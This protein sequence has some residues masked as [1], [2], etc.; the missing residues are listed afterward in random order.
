MSSGRKQRREV[1]LGRR[2][3]LSTASALSLGA[4]AALAMP[5]ATAAGMATLCVFLHAQTNAQTLEKA[6]ESMLPGVTV[7][8]LSRVKDFETRMRQ[9]PDAVLSLPAVLHA[10]ACPVHLQGFRG[11]SSTEAY[12]LLSVKPMAPA[13]VR[14][15]GAVD[16]LGRAHM[17]AFVGNLLGGNTPAVTLVT[18]IVD[19]LPLLQ[20]DKVDAVILPLRSVAWLKA[21]TRVAMSVTDL[22]GGH[23][24][25]PAVSFLSP[26]G[27]RLRELIVK[28][29]P[30]LRAEIGVETWR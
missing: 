22:P 19:L 25:L 15:I 24:G 16:L 18:K 3:F 7:S 28:A 23:V 13:R 27:H 2:A 1:T 20:F 5:P 10:Q 14:T 29:T 26:Q 17:P 12:V 6:L 4:I 21:R 11:G 30:G 8:V 9:Q